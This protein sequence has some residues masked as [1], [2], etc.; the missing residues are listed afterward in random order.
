M[1]RLLILPYLEVPC[2]KQSSSKCKPATCSVWLCD[3][4]IDITKDKRMV[5]W[6]ALISKGMLK[7]I[8][9]IRGIQTSSP[10]PQQVIIV[11]SI[12]FL[13]N[14]LTTSLVQLHNF[15][16]EKLHRSMIGAPTFKW[17]QWGEASVGS[18]GF[19]NYSGQLTISDLSMTELM[20]L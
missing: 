11:A 15:G 20:D 19:K 4:L 17:R 10:F 18:R 9:R 12:T 16:C 1:K 13:I 7:G 14:L 8:K 6:S 2:E 3:L 5:N